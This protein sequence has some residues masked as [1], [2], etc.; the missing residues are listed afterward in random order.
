MAM[1]SP[2]PSL[3]VRSFAEMLT[4]PMY[5]Q[6][7]T[8]ESQKYPKRASAFFRVQYYRPAIQ[9]I[10]DFYNAGSSNNVLVQAISD[11]RSSTMPES[12][13]DNNIRVIRHFRSSRQR[14]RSLAIQHPRTLRVSFHGI[15]LRYTPDVLA[16][17][18]QKQTHILY[19][20]QQTEIDPDDARTT[21]EMV[22]TI[23]F[24]SGAR[25]SNVTLEYV[26]LN[27]RNLVHTIRSVR[28]LTVRRAQQNARAI[29]HLWATI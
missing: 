1:A 4:L 21:L 9:A 22:H 10:R 25:M 8:L 13:K 14:R 15:I 2:M 12:R 24:T 19:N 3:T 23:L 26:D 20:F 18:G 16:I 7:S 17:N 5:K 6:L 27:R 28:V 11:I 29:G